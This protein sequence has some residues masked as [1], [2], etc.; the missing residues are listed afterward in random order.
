MMLRRIINVFRRDR[1]TREIDEELQSHVD[2]ALATVAE[3]NLRVCLSRIA[4]V[5]S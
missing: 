4:E 3:D 5:L 1:L 2:E